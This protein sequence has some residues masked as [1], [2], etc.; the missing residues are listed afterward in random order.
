MPDQTA[1]I[2]VPAG[3]VAGVVEDRRDEIL[4]TVHSAGSVLL[5]GFDELSVD[6]FA[7]VAEILLD[8]VVRK[9]G[10]H[11]LVE[12]SSFVQTPVPFSQERKLLWHNENSFNHRWPLILLL[13]PV[14]TATSGGRTLL[15]DSRELL[16]VLDP[17]IVKLFRERG[18]TYVRRFGNGIGLPWQ[19]VFGT[20]TRLELESRTAA[21]GV[22]VEWGNGGTITTRS[23]RPAIIAHPLT[24]E[25]AWFGQPAH[26]HPACLDDETRE[27][28]ID[29]LGADDLPRDC[30]FGDGSV[31]P[32]SVM[33]ELV[34]AHESIERSIDWI[35][36]DVLIVD[37]VLSSHA[38]D[39]YEGPRRLLVAMG[40]EHE[41]AE[42]VGTETRR[43]A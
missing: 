4:K 25:L 13:S 27:A 11:D 30:L 41:F 20:D 31:I 39:A 18:I 12:A 22:A 5:R 26:W 23:V 21:E 38:R 40:N 29:V 9:N 34:A 17:A 24:G 7:G 32:D 36:G 33:A 15:T 19:K 35:V 1:V 37:N 3:D 43:I 6:E 14:V 10:E 42:R 28:L 2:A 8:D 16:K